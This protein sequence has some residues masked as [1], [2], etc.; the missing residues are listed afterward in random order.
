[1]QRQKEKIMRQLQEGDIIYI[2]K[3]HTVYMDVPGKFIYDNV[4]ERSK[5]SNKLSRTNVEI[6]I[7][8]KTTK[9]IFD[10]AKYIGWYV[11][12]KTL[13]E[14]GGTGHGPHDIYPDG[15]HVYTQKLKRDLTFNKKGLVITFYQSG[16]FNATILPGA[17]EV[18]VG[19]TLKKK[20]SWA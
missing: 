2:D 1:M 9:N 20:E 12:T 7:T 19:K 10:T 17:I 3:G 8:F 13:S 18:L 16:C 5:E 11:V 15:H 4:T 14:G 6:G